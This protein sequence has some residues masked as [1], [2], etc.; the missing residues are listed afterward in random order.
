MNER[1]NKYERLRSI[2]KHNDL[3]KFIG[4]FLFFI[5]NSKL[6]NATSEKNS[7]TC[8]VIHNNTII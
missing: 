2:T 4:F 8:N 5:I 3:G 7:P 1:R 6:F